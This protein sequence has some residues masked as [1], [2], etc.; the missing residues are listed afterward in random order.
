MKKTAYISLFIVAI[1]LFT[2]YVN[3]VK[4]SR[5]Q[6]LSTEIKKDYK[7]Q[8]N[9]VL[10]EYQSTTELV[11]NSIINKEEILFLQKKA[12]DSQTPQERDIYR[13]KL[14]KKL[15]SL[16]KNLKTFGIKQLHFH[17]PDTTSFL[18]F[19]KPKKYG[20]NLKNIR[21]S[22][23]LANTQLQRI[24]GFEEGRIFNGFRYVYPMIYNNEHV[25]SVELSIGFN[26]IQKISKDIYKT[27]QYMILD[28]DI[29]DKKLFNSERSNYKKSYLS[30]N[31]YHESNSFINY[32]TEKIENADMVS[33][34]LFQKINKKV[35]TVL[36]KDELKKYAN[37]VK[38]MKIDDEYYFVTFLPIKNLKN[39]NTGYIISYGFAD[40]YKENNSTYIKRLFIGYFI[41]LLLFLLVYKIDIS[42]I[43]INEI[44]KKERD[45]ALKSSKAKSEF[46]ANMSHEIRTPLNVILGFIDILKD[47]DHG[48]KSIEY[49][50]IIE[51]SSKNLQSIIEDI[52]DFSK[53]ESG[54]LAIDKINFN[55]VDE[56]EST[57]LLFKNSCVE[58]DIDLILN[59]DS[60]IPQLINTDPLRLRQIIINLIS[61][62]IKFTTPHKKINIDISYKNNNLYVSVE[63]EGKGIAAD[64]LDYI[65]TSFSQEDN[66][67]TREY[68]G[69]GLGL[70][71]S[72]KLVKLLGGV[73]KVESVVDEGSRFY[74]SIPAD[75]VD[76]TQKTD[77]K[78]KQKLFTNTK[79]LLVEDNKANQAFMKITLKKMNIEFS[80]ANDG[81]EAI[82]LFNKESF[83]AILMDENMPNMSGIEATKEIL[84][85]EKKSNLTHTPII[86]L[87]AN[88]LKGDRERFLEA[89]MDEYLT[90][91]V[92]KESLNTILNKFI[93]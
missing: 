15:N 72:S 54:K 84:I 48:R 77:S 93:N 32:E 70:S 65:F 44:T 83:D 16:Y 23:L 75:R 64:K 38:F 41:I 69:T 86:A 6:E 59:L 68:G 8:F 88:A 4:N 63:D 40:E 87:T 17:F 82:E 50:N 90:K 33:Y 27:Y 25:G 7:H 14:Y 73:L 80:I 21:H 18:R 85:I 43:N 66:S 52:L 71:I 9:A 10:L 53:I 39:T 67:T 11:F 35:K 62:A 57:I 5:V 28:K 34:Q 13:Q 74:F 47:E 76:I 12:L 30:D 42:N 60:S 89:G 22:L 46:L 92:N 37:F 91:P 61:N 19:H 79:I 20:D 3:S 26:A 58:K 51:N 45:S 31:F 49:I 29:I 56:I 1:S 2:L 36:K 78:R 81:L 24:S 55:V